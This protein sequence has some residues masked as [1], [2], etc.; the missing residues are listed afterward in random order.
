MRIRTSINK[1][2]PTYC[3]LRYEEKNRHQDIKFGIFA[4]RTV[5]INTF[6]D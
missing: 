4:S 1:D 5:K 6:Y 3:S 2:T